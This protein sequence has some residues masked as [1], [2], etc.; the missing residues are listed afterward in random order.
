MFNNADKLQSRRIITYW[1]LSIIL[2]GSYLFLRGSLWQ[3]SAQL[4]T[5][6]EVAATLLAFMIGSMALVRFYSKKNNT[7]LI[8]A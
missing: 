5:L 7:F 6:M 4:H 3:G 1:L 8:C 2:T